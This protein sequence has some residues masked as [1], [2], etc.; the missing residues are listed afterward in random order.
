MGK[1]DTDAR[2]Q[3]V[4]GKKTVISRVLSSDSV[5]KVHKPRKDQPEYLYAIN[6]NPK[7]SKSEWDRKMGWLEAAG[8]R[9]ELITTPGAQI[10]RSGTVQANYRKKIQDKI[11]NISD[12]VKRQQLEDRFKTKDA[13]HAI[14]LQLGGRDHRSNMELLDAGVNSSSGSQIR[15]RNTHVPP[16][17]RIQVFKNDW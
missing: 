10:S 9:G 14:E 16:G 15:A 1:R 6:R 5:Y 13:D 7:H 12:P 17:S 2:A 4:V 3:A 8:K 11:D